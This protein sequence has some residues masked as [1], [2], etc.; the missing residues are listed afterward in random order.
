MEKIDLLLNEY[1]SNPKDWKNDKE[2]VK[3]ILMEEINGFK[4]I[5]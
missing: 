2:K 3:K 4:K 1:V 5:V